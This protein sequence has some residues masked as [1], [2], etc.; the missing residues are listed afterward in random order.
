MASSAKSKVGHMTIEA[1]LLLY[2]VVVKVLLEVLENVFEPQN[3][4]RRCFTQRFM[5]FQHFPGLLFFCHLRGRERVAFRSARAVGGNLEKLVE[6]EAR[7]QLPAA[8]AAMH[9]LQV[10]LAEFLQSQSQSCH[11]PHEGRVHH[12]TVTQIDDELAIAQSQHTPAK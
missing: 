2:R 1:N 6:T 4:F 9:H 12:E 10:S 11:C 7:E 8:F 3:V 5:S